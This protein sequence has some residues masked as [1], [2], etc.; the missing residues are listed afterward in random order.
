MV[1]VSAHDVD[2]TTVGHVSGEW[3]VLQG[4]G[5]VAGFREKPG[6]ATGSRPQVQGAGIRARCGSKTPG[7]LPPASGVPEVSLLQQR[8]AAELVRTH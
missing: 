8:L 7:D 5:T 1:A 6:I 2:P 4:D 3:V